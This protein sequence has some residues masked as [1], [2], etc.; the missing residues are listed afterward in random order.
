M[1]LRVTIPTEVL[2]PAFD[3]NKRT[4]AR[5]QK[6]PYTEPQFIEVPAGTVLDI[7][8]AQNLQLLVHAGQGEPADDE[9]KAVVPEF[10][11]V[12]QEFL[13]ARRDQLLSGHTTGNPKHDQSIVIDPEAFARIRERLKK[14]G[15]KPESE[16]PVH[17]L[18]AGLKLTQKL[19]DN[20]NESIQSA[21]VAEEEPA[22]IP[23]GHDPRSD[24][25][26]SEPDGE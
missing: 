26:D 22:T 20:A 9:A 25:S 11:S 6:Q 4:Q 19:K 5:L 17:I 21:G 16:Q 13:E 3:K 8:S 24:D 12:S 2:N 7:D 15:V 1:Q 10:N 18:Q 23:T 14:H